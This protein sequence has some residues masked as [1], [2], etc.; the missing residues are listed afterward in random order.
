[1]QDPRSCCATA[2]TPP[3]FYVPRSPTLRC[4]LESCD[5]RC[6]A[7]SSQCSQN[8]PLVDVVRDLRDW[9]MA[10]AG[11]G[12]VLAPGGGHGRTGVF[13]WK[14]A[15]EDQGSTPD[16]LLRTLRRLHALG[17]RGTASSTPVGALADGEGSGAGGGGG[18]EGAGGGAGGAAAFVVGEP[19]FVDPRVVDMVA[20]MYDVSV[21]TAAQP[22]CVDSALECARMCASVHRSVCVCARRGCLCHC[23]GSRHQPPRHCAWTLA[24]QSLLLVGLSLS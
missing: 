15:A 16:M 2:P 9:M 11:E 17:Q 14:T 10:G 8:A 24:Q 5:L 3:R 18:A 6:V 1:M 4:V 20:T 12:V 21:S 23:H 22:K 19:Q 7:Q 13:K